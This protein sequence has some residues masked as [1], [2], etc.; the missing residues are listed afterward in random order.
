LD[1]PSSYLLALGQAAE[2]FAGLCIYTLAAILI[3]ELGHAAVG[4]VFGFEIGAVRVGPADLKKQNKWIWGLNKERWDRGFVLAQFRNLPGPLAGLRCFAFILGGPAANLCSAF[5]LAPFSSG[6]T[7]LGRVC[8][9]LMLTCILLGIVNLIPF[10]SKFGLS[11]GAKLLSILF[12]PKWREDFVFRL[13]LK[14]QVREIIS[15]SRNHKLK[16][17]IQ[18]VDELKARFSE[19]TG[20]KPE[21]TLHLEKMRDAFEKALAEASTPKTA[22]QIP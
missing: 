1:V 21:A 22:T 3:H 16:Q 8:G 10:R 19:L 20:V 12:R 14:A 7:P 4:L 13:S 5:L 17:A 18:E 11:D 6:S 9:Y 2:V 15:L